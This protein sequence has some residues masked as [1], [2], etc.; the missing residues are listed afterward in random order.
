V[1]GITETIRSQLMDIIE[2]GVAEGL[3][4]PEVTEMIRHTF[5][6]AKNRAQSIARTEIG[7]VL[8]DS[9]VAAF[10]DEGYT[11]IEW[12]SSRDAKVR[13][14]HLIDGEIVKLGESFS[15]GMRWPFDDTAPADLVI[16]CRCLEL[17]AKNPEAT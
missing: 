3:S 5:G 11:H 1:K 13:S 4:E 14:E 7:G 16:N 2:S 17:P 9:R 8:S 15:N 6:V 12:L 10:I